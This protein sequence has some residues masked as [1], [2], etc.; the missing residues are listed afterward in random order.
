[1]GKILQNI[2]SNIAE[3]LE[4]RTIGRCSR[5]V[6]KVRFIGEPPKP[7]SFYH[8]P[9]LYDLHNDD[10][11]E[12]V[13]MKGAQ[14]G[15]TE[16][17]LNRTLF[18]L[19]QIKV[20]VLYALPNE[21][22]DAMG[23][24]KGRINP[25]AD[26][27]PYIEGLFAIS[28][29]EGHKITKDSKSLYIRGARSRI[30]FKQIDVGLVVLDELDEMTDEAVNLARYRLAGQPRFK[31]LIMLSTP[32]IEE[33]GIHKQFLETT[34][35]HFFFPCPSCG[36]Q[37]ELSYPKCIK[38]TAQDAT[39]PRVKGSYYCCPECESKIDHES[40][41]EHLNKGA[42][43]PAHPGRNTQ[44]YTVNQM[45]SP[46]V[47]PVELAMQE[48]RSRFDIVAKTEFYNSSLGLCFV[49]DDAKITDAIINNAMKDYLNGD[50]GDNQKRLITMGVDVGQ[51]SHFVTVIGWNFDPKRYSPDIT[52]ASIGKL[53]YYG[54]I[55]DIHQAEDI[56]KL[57]QPRMTIFDA[58]PDTKNSIEI[59][60]KYKGIA[61]VCYYSLTKSGKQIQMGNVNENSIS[62]NRTFWLDAMYNKFKTNTM[63]LPQNLGLDIREHLKALV[64]TY[65][66]NDDG[67]TYSEYIKKES[68]PDHYA[69][70]MTYATIALGMTSGHG[71][72]QYI[73][74]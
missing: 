12:I 65:K 31:Q 5:W 27:S 33:T 40:K 58:Q 32:H 48:L 19:D 7:Y 67:G 20:N 6:N 44:G 11:Q 4:S 57:W 68:A 50:Q 71:G 41:A 66:R 1:M 22:P 16:Y 69:H 38:I 17:A 15:F 49:A 54:T 39:D 18:A 55:S 70:A 8:Y 13:I 74:A 26:L 23:F 45:Y 56:M 60:K 52:S 14:L 34:Q 72:N 25:A 2:R 3:S 10:S 29:G 35:N 64:K 43:V 47:T 62:V 42:W 63:S 28:K 30:C 24:S 53:L 9:W 21:R 46:T 73:G 51:E 59:C 61:Y 37:I 36:K